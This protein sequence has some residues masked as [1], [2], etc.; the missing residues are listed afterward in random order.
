MTNTSRTPDANW[1]L[2]YKPRPQML[3]FHQRT[4]R[5]AFMICHRRFG[6]TVAAIGE[7]VIRALYTKKENAQYV[8]FAPFR[9]Q[10]KQIAW[11]YLVDMTDG[12]ATEVKVSELSVTL[13]NN[14]KIM[15]MGADNPNAARGMYFDG[16]VLDEYANMRPDMLDAVIM[17]TLLDRLGWLLVIGTAAG[18][19]N[20]FFDLYEKAQTD[21][22][23][24]FADIKVSESAVIAPEEI[25]RIKNAVS[26]AKFNQ[27]FMNDFSAELV[28]TYYAALV[29]AAERNNQLHR[30]SIYTPD[31]PVHVAMD[32]GRGDSTVMIYWQERPDGL[33]VID[34][35][36]NNGE[37]A[38]HYIDVLA[39]TPEYNYATVWLPHDAKAKTFATHKSA[40]EQ[41]IDAGLPVQIT[42]RLSV[43]DGIEA[44]RQTIPITHFDYR[45]ERAYTL[46]EAARTYRKKFDE[47]HQVFSNTP[48]HSYESDFCDALRYMAIVANPKRKKLE[49]QQQIINDVNSAYEHNLDEMFKQR[50]NRHTTD[51]IAKLRI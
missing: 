29:N 4:Q 19:L 15:L 40:M 12:I 47:K 21:K 6:K 34:C 5:F 25:A 26:E 37:Q 24:F 8:Y 31:L 41:F 46:V 23:W 49:L 38:Q 36:D 1:E 30:E 20:K 3:A 16:A 7:L 44:T 51:N 43:E 2:D 28:G 35:Y 22:E 9:Q 45:R 32:I 50:E 48:L 17:P 33:A 39:D 42:P 11:N 14:A 10:A 18:R 27:E 13:P